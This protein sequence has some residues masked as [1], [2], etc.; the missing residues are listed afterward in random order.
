MCREFLDKFELFHGD[1]KGVEEKT[2]T[3][4]GD[5]LSAVEKS[6]PQISIP[7]LVHELREVIK[8]LDERQVIRARGDGKGGAK[9]GKTCCTHAQ[10]KAFEILL[11]RPCWEE[12]W[13]VRK[14]VKYAS[15]ESDDQA[16]QILMQ[17]FAELK[18]NQAA[19]EELSDRES[20]QAMELEKMRAKDVEQQATIAQLR[21]ELRRMH[22]AAAYVSGANE[23]LSGR[24]C[25]RRALK[26]DP[27]IHMARDPEIPSAVKPEGEIH[28]LLCTEVL[29]TDGLLD[30][31]V[32]GAEEVLELMSYC[33][34]DLEERPAVRPKL[35]I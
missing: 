18:R 22:D 1:W 8:I 14:L 11:N 5:I 24:R 20:S 21:N 4:L 31:D 12:G 35:E 23:K 10:K 16:G 29:P 27:E 17:L 19:L 34:H 33:S 25:S 6:S 3:L 30:V 9:K 26:P 32:L 28:E 13:D 2:R 15:R 7:T